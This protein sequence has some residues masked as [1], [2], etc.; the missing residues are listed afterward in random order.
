MTTTITTKVNIILITHETVGTAL[1]HA[2]KMALNELPLSTT[3]MAITHQDE[4]DDI[5]AKL[6]K[7]VEALIR[8]NSEQQFLILTDLFGATPSNIASRLQKCEQKDKIEIVAG[9]NLPML[10]RV[11]NYATLSLHD[12]T[13]KAVSG[14]KDGI[15]SY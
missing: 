3:V 9:L 5:V 11:M 12:L 7:H 10:I 13:Q 2:A 14:G 8:K 1:L 4:P 6:K 15:I